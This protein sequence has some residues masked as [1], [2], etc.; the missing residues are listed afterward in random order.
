MTDPNV[1]VS[2]L[3]GV[4]GGSYAMQALGGDRVSTECSGE[5]AVERP[6]VKE[7]TRLSER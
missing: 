2:K 7:A 1:C 4:R 5:D 6:V 3:A